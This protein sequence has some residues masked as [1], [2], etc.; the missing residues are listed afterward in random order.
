MDCHEK[1]YVLLLLLMPEVVWEDLSSW[2]ESNISWKRLELYQFSSSQRLAYGL[3]EECCKFKSP[4]TI[5]GEPETMDANPI[6]DAV[7]PR[8]LTWMLLSIQKGKS[9]AL[10]KRRKVYSLWNH[11]IYET[12]N[13]S[14]H[15]IYEV[16]YSMKL[17]DLR[18]WYNYMIDGIT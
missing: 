11:M 15:R 18:N 13:S 7:D 3:R 17:N 1:K 9:K 8:K 4:K 10:I 6:V 14:N 12:H 2:S 5:V 16:T